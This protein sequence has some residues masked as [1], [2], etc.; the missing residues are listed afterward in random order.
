MLYELEQAW[1]ERRDLMQ[2][3]FNSYRARPIPSRLSS[4]LHALIE[5]KIAYEVY[6]AARRSA[7]NGS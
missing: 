6:Q 2:A 4:L 1:N 3:A 5:Y 7:S